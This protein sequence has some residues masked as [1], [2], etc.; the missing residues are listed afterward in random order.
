MSAIGPPTPVSPSGGSPG[1]KSPSL[2]GRLK[3]VLSSSSP[4]TPSPI[5]G[6][7]PVQ[8]SPSLSLVAI[9]AEETP[10]DLVATL[11]KDYAKPD[12]SRDV[13]LLEEAIASDLSRGMRVDI[14]GTP[15]GS[16]QEYRSK[17]QALGVS[18]ELIEEGLCLMQ[19]GAGGVAWG[20]VSSQL[21]AGHV[22]RQAEDSPLSVSL[23]VNSQGEVQGAVTQH[24]RLTALSSGEIR[25][26]GDVKLVMKV[27]NL[28]DSDARQGWVTEVHANAQAAPSFNR[29]LA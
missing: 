16:I 24:Y 20:L 26:G 22:L 10:T 5:K 23:Q 14:N 17:M 6:A 1:P 3:S 27:G 9:R 7:T 19:Q 21:S 29:P 28:A 11:W 25:A 2:W 8:P 13:G 15:V 12:G 18:S 4:S